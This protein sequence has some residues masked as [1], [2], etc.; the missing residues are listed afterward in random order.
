VKNP[1]P[2]APLLA[3]PRPCRVVE[4]DRPDSV[5]NRAAAATPQADPACCRSEWQLSFHEAMKPQRALVVREAGG[6]VAA[7]ALAR[8][9]RI[10]PLLEPIESHWCFGSPLLGPDAVELLAALL[11]EPR[12]RALRPRVLVS[13]VLPRSRLA[14]RLQHVLGE[15]YDIRR[16]PLEVLC[17]ASL[18]GG[19]DGYLARRSPK[20]RTRLRQAARRAAARGVRFERH[21]PA[22]PAEADALY[23]RILA[24]ERTSWKGP[25][26]QGLTH[27][28][29]QDFYARLLRRL[30]A[31]G[32]AR[33][34]LAHAEGRDVG[35]VFGGL[36]GPHY[37]GQQFSYARDW[38]A[39][40]IG[41]LLQV[42]MIGWLCEE[43]V[44]QYDMG[45]WM[46]YKGRWAE[47]EVRA[48]AR[49]LVASLG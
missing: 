48:T 22:S 49:L 2:L 40:S 8:H 13:G 23:A 18:E 5:W 34:V 36:A 41:N 44:E 21:A 47:R 16:L 45:P 28:R 39:F 24:V 38:H 20:L 12:V 7:F 11:D 29:S 9:P 1:V 32:T 15:R 31:A 27:P 19:L 26:H 25:G 33:I 14:R 35:F 6:S 42:E 10:G 43:G 30:A 3:A 37:R 17:S 4:L 46:A